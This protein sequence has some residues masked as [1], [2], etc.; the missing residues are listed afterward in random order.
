MWLREE[1]ST[2]VEYLDHIRVQSK[3]QI[4]LLMAKELKAKGYN[5]IPGHFLCCQCVKKYNIMEGDQ[6]ES[7]VE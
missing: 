7:Y 6:N 5:V 1:L 3:K 2:A 4:Y